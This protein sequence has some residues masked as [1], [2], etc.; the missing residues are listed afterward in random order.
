MHILTKG[1]VPATTQARKYLPMAFQPHG[2][3][4]GCGKELRQV[5]NIVT[6]LVTISGRHQGGEKNLENYGK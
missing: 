4:S 6:E 3:G 1:Q 5:T 2:L